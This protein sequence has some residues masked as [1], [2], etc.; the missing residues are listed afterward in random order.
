[1]RP[2][3]RLTKATAQ[4]LIALFVLSCVSRGHSRRLHPPKTN[5]KA[6]NSLLNSSS[7]YELDT[8]F[9][10][11]RVAIRSNGFDK[12]ISIEFGN[13]R[14]EIL[15]FTTRS[16]DDGNLVAGDI[17]R[18]GDVDLIWV[19]GAD[20]NNAVVL[21]NQ[22]GGN[23]AAVTDNTPYASELDE[24]FN[25]DDSPYKRSLK[26]HRKS[27]SLTSSSFSGIGPGLAARIHAPTVQNRLVATVERV[28][29]RLA[30]FTQVPKRGPPSILS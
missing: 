10:A 25:T 28:A 23:F 16:D 4:L 18:D 11:D 12:T 2:G 17:D 15:G 22:G 1:V 5:S 26:K 20:P 8:D 30:I 9:K 21:I 19:G 3:I 27:S 29:D 14:N 13:S 6:T 7:A 24:L